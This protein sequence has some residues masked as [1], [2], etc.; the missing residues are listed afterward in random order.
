MLN[1][2]YVFPQPI[3]WTDLDIDLKK[4]Q[5]IV[6]DIAKSM[7]GKDRSNRGEL[8]Y[9]S[10]DFYAE[11]VVAEQDDEFSRL[12]TL[13]K[14]HGQE[15]FDSYEA[16]VTHLEFA[17]AWININNKGGYNETH[18]HPGA[19]MSGA[20]YVKVPKEGDS[21]S[22]VFHR[23]P[24]EAYTIHSLGL[25]EDMSTAEELHT[26]ATWTYPPTEN[27]LVLF[28]AWMPHG[29]RENETDEDRISISFNL[30]PNR[31]QRNFTDIIKSH[32]SREN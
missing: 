7:P 20:F 6:Y 32:A 15:A 10:P 2:D 24:M 1:L 29:V 16:Q 30:I 5:E 18:T 13:I 9:Q 21:G 23:N 12:L 26:F 17:N 31:E 14:K 28:P 4:L 3:W 22:I 27:R 11:K 8:N 25:A 19:L